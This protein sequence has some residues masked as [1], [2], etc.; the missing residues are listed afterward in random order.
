M[1]GGF[2]VDGTLAVRK[3]GSALNRRLLQGGTVLFQ[4]ET[5]AE[6]GQEQV[7]RKMQCVLLGKKKRTA[8]R[9]CAK[10]IQFLSVALAAERFPIILLCRLLLR[11][12]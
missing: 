1:P 10:S 4:I 9:P 7:M 11:K 5:A 3:G 2:V 6:K 12:R 8:K